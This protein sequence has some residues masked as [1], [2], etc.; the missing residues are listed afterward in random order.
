M[1]EKIKDISLDSFKI[2]NEIY[3][4]YYQVKWEV[5]EKLEEREQYLKI[6][7]SLPAFGFAKKSFDDL[8][9]VMMQ[10]AWD[11]DYILLDKTEYCNYTLEEFDK[12][13]CGIVNM[14]LK[15]AGVQF[16]AILEGLFV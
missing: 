10:K 11:D 14:Q 6:K 2:A 16:A 15:K 9:L 12:I 7:N 3:K 1:D 4:H 8:N 5:F 13:F